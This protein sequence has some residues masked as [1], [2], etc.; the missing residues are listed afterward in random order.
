[1]KEP[2]RRLRIGI[3]STMGGNPWGGSEELWAATASEALNAGHEVFVS[4]LGWIKT[5]PKLAEL[6]RRGAKILRRHNPDCEFQGSLF[7]AAS[8]YRDLFKTKPDVLVIS[9]AWSFDVIA[10]SDLLELLYVTPIPFVL[11][12]QFNENL[13]LLTDDCHREHACNIYARAFR[14]LFVSNQNQIDAERQLAMKISNSDL[15][16]NPVNLSDCSHLPWPDSTTARLANVARLEAK[17]KGQDILIEALSADQ[18]RQRDWHLTLYGS[19][20]DERYLRSLVEF[21]GLQGRITFAGHQS[22]VRAIWA[23]EQV[24][25]MFSR[26]E[27]IPLALVEAMLCGRPAIVSN[28]GGNQEWVTEAQTGFVAEAPV[29]GLA[30]AA[31]ERAWSARQSWNAM[32]LQAHKFATGKISGSSNRGLLDVLVEAQGHQR[33]AGAATREEVARPKQYRELMEQ[34]KLVA[35]MGAL[36][37]RNIVVRWRA[38][39]LRSLLRLAEPRKPH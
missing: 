30:R 33:P 20:R 19:G 8:S 21:F 31:L 13:P 1:M 23:Q 22:D 39:R 3:I 10:S 6:E 16:L 4:V 18:W 29:I 12:C 35:E 26:A 36:Y 27:G 11:V 28:V 34:A 32:G 9:Q 37:F 7:G 38:A 15:V 17:A 25:V 2:A 24:L 14:V 5:P